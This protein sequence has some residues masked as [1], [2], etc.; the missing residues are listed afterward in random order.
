MA[1]IKFD[2]SGSDPAKALASGEVPKPGLYNAILISAEP[3]FKKGDDGTPDKSAP[4]LEPIVRINH[5]GAKSPDGEDANGGM[6]YDYL[7]FTEAS[8]WKMDQFLQAFGLADAKKRKG[9]LDTDKLKSRPCRIR[10]KAGTWEGNYSPKIAAWLPAGEG[11]DGEPDE[12]ALDD[13]GDDIEF[14]DLG[15]DAGED[16]GDADDPFAEDGDDAGDDDVLTR[17]YLEGLASTD[18]AKL[19]LD[20]FDIKVSA[21]PGKG[22]VKL[23]NCI[24][25]ILAAQDEDPFA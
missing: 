13:A 8:Q 6:M 19:A 12:F 10:V 2:V 16:A 17:E 18:L 3:G 7:S 1:K 15:G 14:E 5:P 22:K 4:R 21:V 24:D 11:D 25:Q 9:V 23:K 20:K